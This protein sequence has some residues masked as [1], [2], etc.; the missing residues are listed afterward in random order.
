MN[1]YLKK[2][3]YKYY[4]TN[5]VFPHYLSIK[6]ANIYYIEYHQYYVNPVKYSWI[7]KHTEKKS[8]FIIFIVYFLFISS[9][10]H[11]IIS[12]YL[13][14]QYR[15]FYICLE[16]LSLVNIVVNRYWCF[17]SRK[18]VV[19]LLRLSFN[20]LSRAFLPYRDYF[21]GARKDWSV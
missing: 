5:S 14:S 7:I 8:I 21:Y 17:N 9:Y 6:L 12:S 18:V 15:W 1:H 20:V 13:N 3:F 10:H 11:I 4:L 16:I 2:Y 19:I